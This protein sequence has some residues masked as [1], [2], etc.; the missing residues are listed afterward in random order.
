MGR[1]LDAYKEGWEKGDAEMILGA[2]ADD[3]VYDDPIN[4]RLTKAEFASYLEQELGGEGAASSDADEQFETISDMVV[5][6]KDGE[7]TA[8]AWWKTA[9]EEGAELVKSGPDGV[10]LDKLAYYTRP[11]PS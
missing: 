4:G 10:H 3:F 2:V 8:W 5:Q 6:E 7:E 11:Q 9:S 1:H